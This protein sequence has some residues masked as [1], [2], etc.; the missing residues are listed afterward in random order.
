[1]NIEQTLAIFQRGSNEILPLDELRDKLKR[2]KILK[3]KAGFDPTAPDLHLGHTVL[4]N[5]LKQLQDLGHE[6][7]FLIG[8]FTAMIGDP[9]GKSKTRPPLSREQVQENAKSY[10]Q[11]VFKILDKNKTNIVFNSQWIDKLTPIEFVKLASMRTVARMLERND[12]EARHKN[13]DDIAIHEFL[14]P[15]AQGYDSVVLE[16]DIEVGGTD[17]KFNLLMG[18]ELQKRYGKEQQVILTMPILEGLDGVQKMSKSLNN[19]IAID[20]NPDDMF[21]KIMSISDKL[22]WRYFEL[23]SFESLETIANLKQEMTQGKN[24]RDIKFILADEIITRFHNAESAKQAQQNFIDRFSKNQIPN[25]ME[26]F[27]FNAGVKIANLLK[28]AG[29]C[30]STSNAYQMI[31]QGAAKING[32]KITNKNLEP[33]IGTEVYQVGKRKFARV[34]IK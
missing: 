17:Q 7:Q 12:F 20:D 14:Y 33:E 11:Q 34:T 6:I 18:R 31:K 22:M 15:L 13:G 25:E 19:Y 30:P 2:K 29:L 23:L 21:G 28:D 1:M 9:T 10:T 5:K 27:N 26:E 24:P 4:I 3:I 32:E 16:S 8:D